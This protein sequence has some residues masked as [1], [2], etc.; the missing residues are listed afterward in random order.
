MR[1]CHVLGTVPD[2]GGMTVSETPA[3]E[4]CALVE[5]TDRKTGKSTACHVLIRAAETREEGKT[6]QEPRCHCGQFWSP[7][8]SGGDRL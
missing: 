2:T 6:R 4:A 1:A 7:G 8:P 3:Q 5:E